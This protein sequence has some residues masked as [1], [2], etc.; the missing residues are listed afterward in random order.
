M[1][2][3][4][5]IGKDWSFHQ[6]DQFIQLDQKFDINILLRQWLNHST[7]MLVSLFRKTNFILLKRSCV[8]QILQK[9]V[10]TKGKC[11]QWV[12][13]TCALARERNLERPKIIRISLYRPTWAKKHRLIMAIGEWHQEAYRESYRSFPAGVTSDCFKRSRISDN[14]DD[15]S[16][17][18]FKAWN[19]LESGK[20]NAD[21]YS[22]IKRDSL[23]SD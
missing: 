7:G 3:Q 11:L 12:R 18:K 1:H 20:V 9:L 22:F 15:V 14:S 23:P 16:K 6:T 2:L 4:S 5:E 17:I 19:I 8:I 13:G 10:S 21:E